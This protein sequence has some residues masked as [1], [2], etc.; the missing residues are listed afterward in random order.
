MKLPS[1]GANAVGG[2]APLVMQVATSNAHCLVATRCGKVYAWGSNDKGQLGL[3]GGKGGGDA[4]GG[5]GVGGTSVV[6]I[7]RRVDSLAR[8]SVRH[9]SAGGEHSACCASDG[10]VFCWGFGVAS[11]CKVKLPKENAPGGLRSHRSSAR[12]LGLQTACGMSHA[13]VMTS[14][15]Q[16][17]V[18]DA[19]REPRAV[20]LGGGER[21][22]AISAAGTHTCRDARRARVHMGGALA[23]V[24]VAHADASGRAQPGVDGGGGGA[25]LRG[26]DR[27]AQSA[28]AAT[29]GDDGW[30][31][32]DGRRR[33]DAPPRK[34]GR[35]DERGQQQ[36]RGGGGGHGG[37]AD[38]RGGDGGGAPARRLLLHH[39]PLHSPLH[40]PSRAV[41]SLQRMCEDALM[42]AASPRESLQLLY[43][44]DTI[45]CHV[46]AAYLTELI[47]CNLRLV[48]RKDLW[49]HLPPHLLAKLR[50]VLRGSRYEEIEAEVEAEETSWGEAD[51]MWAGSAAEAEATIAAMASGG[52]ARGEQR[53]PAS[54]GLSPGF[55]PC[56]SPL[57]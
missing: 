6:V 27:V 56:L 52:M 51:L 28:G 20:P 41:P 24:V 14:D 50:G 48:L 23:L 2:V 49:A 53:A 39:V 18:W 15:G 8:S 13:A 19:S 1:N 12:P 55:S 30:R 45:G 3:G 34:L 10:T 4:G 5:D 32:R 22:V 21:A 29:D 46:A 38:L 35:G 16:L 17:Y 40:V 7:P 57:S 36:R 26:G 11:P 9:V 44:C 37:G 42:R 25:P 31:Q 33:C 54:P 43:T 47:A